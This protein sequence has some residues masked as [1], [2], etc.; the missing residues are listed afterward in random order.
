MPTTKL[1]ALKPEFCQTLPRPSPVDADCS[2]LRTTTQVC[3]ASSVLNVSISL[4]TSTMAP[5]LFGA[6]SDLE[7]RKGDPTMIMAEQTDA[8]QRSPQQ[9]LARRESSLSNRAM[10]FVGEVNVGQA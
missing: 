6:P 2:A 4:R 1:R 10:T 7:H 9:D 5:R 3:L 8:M